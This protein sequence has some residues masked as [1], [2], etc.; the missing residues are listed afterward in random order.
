[1]NTLKLASATAVLGLATMLSSCDSSSPADTA[2]STPDAAQPFKMLVYTRTASFRHDSIPTAIKTIQELGAANNFSV[3]AT[4]DPAQFTDENLAQYKVIAFVSTTGDV[5]DD[6]QQGAF[7]RWMAKGNGY[8]GVHS[9]SDTEYDWPFY[10]EMVGAYFLCHPVFPVYAKGGPGVQPG[11][12]H[13]EAPDHP[14]VAHLPL[15]W[16]VSDEFYSFQT[17]PRG[18]VRVLMT[19]DED[20]YNQYPN[21]SNLPTSPTFPL[22]VPGKMGDHPMSWCHDYG[23]G[24]AFYT[25]LGHSEAMYAIPEYRLHLLN[26][27]LTAAGRLEADCTP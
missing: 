11:E 8:V 6:T 14:A 21:T 19:V 24:R 4:E 12:F 20:S 27:I 9:A 25:E 5:L 17:N 10:G 3:D 18:K 16:T 22:G 13:V 7:E 15:P 26:G 2:K 23:G 1:M